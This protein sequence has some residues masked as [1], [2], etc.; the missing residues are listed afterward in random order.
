MCLI[1]T[2]P[3]KSLIDPDMLEEAFDNNSDGF[4]IVYA[5]ENRLFVCKRL[6]NFPT[7][8]KLLEV[9]PDDVPL[10]IHFRFATHGAVDVD[11]VHP[12]VVLNSADGD[13]C[14]LA[15]MHNGVISN[16]GAYNTGHWSGGKWV[17]NE[18]KRSDTAIYLED[19]L[20]PIIKDN[21]SI[22]ENEHFRKMI[23][24]DIGGG[25]KLLFIRGD[26]QIFYVN[27]EAGH[28]NKEYPDVWFSNSYSFNKHHRGNKGSRWVNPSVAPSVSNTSVNT[29]VTS[30]VNNDVKNVH[31]TPALGG[32]HSSAG[33]HNSSGEPGDDHTIVRTTQN[34]HVGPKSSSLEFE[35]SLD[36]TEEMRTV[37]KALSRNSVNEIQLIR[38]KQD[39]AYFG[40]GWVKEGNLIYFG[41]ERIAL[42]HKEWAENKAKTLK[43]ASN[44][45]ELRPDQVI[46]EPK[47][48]LEDVAKILER[49][50]NVSD[51]RSR[52]SAEIMQWVAEYPREAAQ[53]LITH[54][55]MGGGI[56]AVEKYVQG[57][58]DNVTEAIY[59]HSHNG[60][61]IQM[62]PPKVLDEPSVDDI[63]YSFAM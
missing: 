2:A 51:F 1:T 44:V 14:D 61:I 13:A 49:M 23:K 24:R 47:K 56:L 6:S 10:A 43:E 57:N 27:K 22:I 50:L 42:M 33:S 26:G 8:K 58:L 29:G 20:R 45:L 54:L 55:K 59:E 60:R 36:I 41:G 3:K 9:V 62:K 5:Q 38:P 31:G 7:F 12:F 4:G 52:S 17:R 18:D 39:T 19:H 21:P 11:N 48:P 28:E 63:D 37:L 16:M 53:Y 35:F 32:A 40:W 30:T 25:N 46:S 15:M 34:E